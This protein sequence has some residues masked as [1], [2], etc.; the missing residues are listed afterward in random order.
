[1]SISLEKA[2]ELYQ[3]KLQELPKE[4]AT[5]KLSAVNEFSKYILSPGKADVTR[6]SQIDYAIFFLNIKKNNSFLTVRN[7]QNY[8]E[9]FKDYLESKNLLGVDF[10]QLHDLMKQNPALQPVKVSKDK[11]IA[12]AEKNALTAFSRDELAVLFDEQRLLNLKQPQE[13]FGLLLQ[14][15]TGARVSEVCGLKVQNFFKQDGYD[16]V[17]FESDEAEKSNRISLR[18]RTIPLHPD[19]IA[20]GLLDYVA[21]IKSKN[22]EMIFPH[23]IKSANGFGGIQNKFFRKYLAQTHKILIEQQAQRQ[24]G[25]TLNQSSPTQPKW[26][27]AK[28][29]D[30]NPKAHVLGTDSFRKTITLTLLQKKVNPYSIDQ[31][32]GR[33][34]GTYLGYHQNNHTLK[35]LFD[36]VV[37][38]IETGLDL[39]KFKYTKGQFD[40]IIAE[41]SAKIQAKQM[42][43][44]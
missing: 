29:L 32:L 34:I 6:I 13:Y 8:I 38:N 35:D 16:C 44:I 14:L 36:N 40:Q 3:I 33:A 21:D 11:K 42:K 41:K 23:L 7:K 26:V 20:L 43:T 27:D 5:A 12:S 37:S 1:M 28:A 10:M 9:D 30:P 2:I 24:D 15:Y 17:K 4:T 22:N 31:Y 18:T 25:A 39:S 19:L